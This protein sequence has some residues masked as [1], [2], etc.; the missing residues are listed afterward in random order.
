MDCKEFISQMT[1]GGMTP[2][3]T[4]IML[5]TSQDPPQESLADLNITELPFADRKMKT[6]LEPLCLMPRMSTFAIGA[7]INLIVSQMP[8]DQMFVNVGVWHGFTF[9]SGLVNNGDKKC[10]GVDNFSEFGSPRQEFLDRFKRLKQDKH[11]FHDICYREY[12]R[13]IHQGPIGFYF[14]DGNH[15]RE[16]QCMGLSLAEPFLA[17]GCKILIDD[18]NDIEGPT[19]GTNDFLENSKHNYEVIVEQRT[20]GNCHPTFWNGIMIL[21]K[22]D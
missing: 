9:L 12:F 6:D 1:F 19:L 15:S 4:G 3:D 20:A 21:E 5:L 8:S 17:K 14:Y 13:T 11:Q 16:D 10:V 7:A 22:L 18:I 2:F